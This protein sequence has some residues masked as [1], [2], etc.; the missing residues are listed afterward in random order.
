[1]KIDIHIKPPM[2]QKVNILISKLTFNYSKQDRIDLSIIKQI[3]VKFARKSF[4][5]LG[6][7]KSK[8]YKI[9]IEYYEAEVLE[10][11]LRFRA[12]LEHEMRHLADEDYYSLIE[13]CGFLNQKIA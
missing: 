3:A 1:M 13:F 6:K 10:R 2:L 4:S 11:K 9:S 7:D 8:A 12:N 5:L